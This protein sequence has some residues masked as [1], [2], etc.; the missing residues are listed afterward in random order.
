MHLA[1]TFIQSDL[2]CI[3]CINFISSCITF[4]VELCTI[5]ALDQMFEKYVENVLNL[6]P[7][8][9]RMSLFLHQIWRNVALHHLLI[10]GSSAV[11]GCRQ[12]ESPNS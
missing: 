1:D 3:Q 6:G 2:H 10:N 4:S 11:N 7:Y 5:F 8:K 9:I 12:N